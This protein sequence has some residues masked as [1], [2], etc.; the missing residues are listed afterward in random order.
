LTCTAAT[1]APRGSPCYRRSCSDASMHR[2]IDAFNRRVAR[3]SVALK[4]RSRWR[5]SMPPRGGRRVTPDRRT[6]P[7]VLHPAGPLA[8]SAQK[9]KRYTHNCFRGKCSRRREP[10]SIAARRSA[11]DKGFVPYTGLSTSATK[12]FPTPRDPV[13]SAVHVGPWNAPPISHRVER[14]SAPA[15]TCGQRP[16]PICTSRHAP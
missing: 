12:Y 13:T 5:H 2:C 4:F 11:N 1:G 10:Q 3:T 7:G 6:R 14:Q 8:T 16:S 9:P 15:R